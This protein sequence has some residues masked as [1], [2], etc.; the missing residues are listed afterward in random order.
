M[1]TDDSFSGH[2][3]Q[4][5]MLPNRLWVT[6]VSKPVMILAKNSVCSVAKRDEKKKD[7]S[8]MKLI[9]EEGCRVSKKKT[10]LKL[11]CNKK[12]IRCDLKYIHKKLS[13]NLQLRSNNDKYSEAVKKRKNTA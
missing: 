1:G 3:L 9:K 11:P 2:R 10:K 6:E 13:M 7:F 5:C 4:L 12:G 8:E